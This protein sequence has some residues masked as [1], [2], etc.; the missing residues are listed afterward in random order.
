MNAVLK[1][2]DW[3]QQLLH[4]R[5]QTV[6]D[7]TPWAREVREEAQEA[8]QHLGFPDRKQEAWRY[9]NI[10]SLLTHTFIPAQPDD[11]VIVR[12]ID[13]CF[14]AGLDA[15]RLV[16]LDNRFRADLSSLGDLPDGV[17]VQSLSQAV[18]SSPESLQDSFGHVADHKHNTFIALNT[19]LMSDGLFIHVRDNVRVDKPIEVLYLISSRGERVTSIPRVLVVLSAGAKAT[20]IERFGGAGHSFYFQDF[21]FQNMVEEIVLNDNAALS[22]YRLLEEQDHAFHLSNINVCQQGGS[23]YQAM[24]LDLSGAWLRTNYEINFQGQGAGCDLRGLYIV[25]GKQQTNLHTNILHHV[26]GCNSQQNFKGLLLGSGRAVFDGRIL[27]DK[28]A[29]LTDAHLSNSNLMLSE[30]SE[31]DTKPQLEIYADNVKC[32]HGTTVGQLDPEQLFYLRSRGIEEAQAY[33]MLCQG[34]ATE[35][36]DACDIEAVRKHVETRVER[37]LNV[38][39]SQEVVV[40]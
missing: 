31:V 17:V 8:F 9:S 13:Q 6:F 24:N 16:F 27:V 12:D 29:Q 21:Y 38:D 25:N 28:Q 1:A 26:P 35:I 40:S 15:H 5:E 18:Q 36:V 32:S 33:R 19:A 11:K 39:H 2:T 20:L 30:E 34:F 22:H 3:Y 4:S 37:S 14:T 10:Q 23:H 7:E